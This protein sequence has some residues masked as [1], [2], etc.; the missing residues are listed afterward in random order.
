MGRM[1]ETP[2]TDCNISFAFGENPR[3]SPRI[4]NFLAG[5]VSGGVL[6][7]QPGIAPRGNV[8]KRISQ[9]MDMD[10]HIFTIFWSP[11]EVLIEG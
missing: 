4:I 11:S 6:Q 2:P 8:P 1:I 10:K 5:Q 3:T 7:R 9:S